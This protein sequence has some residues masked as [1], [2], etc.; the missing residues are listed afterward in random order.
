MLDW[1]DE[2]YEIFGVDAQTFV[3]TFENFLELVHPE[4]RKFV[5]LV[6]R[7]SLDTGEAFS[8]DERIVRPDGEERVLLSS[9]RVERDVD[10]NPARL[11][12]VCLDITERQH[13]ERQLARVSRE[14]EVILESAA[15]GILGLDH[16]GK[17]SFANPAAADLL[18][19]LPDELTGRS[20]HDLVHG[21]RREAPP[22]ALDQ[23][24]VLVALRTGAVQHMEEDVFWRQD[25]ASFPVHYTSS[26]ILERGAPTGAVVTFND[27][28]ERKRFEAQLQYLADHDPVTGLFNRRRFE[29]ELARHLAYDA[30][31]GRGGAVLALDLDNFKDVN[32]TLGHKAGD[33]VITRVA[34]NIR[35]R[36]RETD[37]LARFGGDEFAVLLPEAGLEQ[38]Q[39]VAQNIIDAIRGQPIT[40]AGRQ[41]N[42]TGSIGIT[43]FGGREDVNG[44]QLLVE[45]D[46]AMY[47]AK[48]AGRDRFSPAPPA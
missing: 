10:G 21:P 37:T 4:D 31:Y 34:R 45:A 42:V 44:E 32:D 38:A 16:E 26:P 46:V 33:E 6:S 15:E 40:I 24:P 39:S 9:G 41:I 28:T 2:L 47:A 48:A 29:Q 43:T 5:A 36:I 13:A 18:G 20:I 35:D 22:H 7:G 25:G 8:I 27:V 3:P 14:Q 30:R 19:W 23:C 12:G 11:V 17:V 1:S